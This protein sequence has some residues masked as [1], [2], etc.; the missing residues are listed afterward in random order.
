[1]KPDIAVSGLIGLVIGGFVFLAAHWY[2][3]SIP[4]RLEGSIAIAIAFLVLLLIALLEMPVMVWALQRM[5][6][7]ASTPRVAV[8]GTHA[9]YNC[10]AAVYAAAFLLLT[11]K[12]TLAFVLAGLGLLR[13]VSGIWIR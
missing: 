5:V 11:G 6:R 8:L 12:E 2:K 10:F 3:N 7:D 1:M 13:F 4:L 9:V